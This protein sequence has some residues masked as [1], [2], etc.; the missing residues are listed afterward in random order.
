MT[1]TNKSHLKKNKN[2]K[3]LNKNCIQRQKWKNHFLA[4]AVYSVIALDSIMETPRYLILNLD[5]PGQLIHHLTSWLDSWLA[6]WPINCLV[7]WLADEFLLV[8]TAQQYCI[9]SGGPA[10]G[11]I[12]DW[13]TTWP[14][15]C[16]SDCR[17]PEKIQ[18]LIEWLID[19]DM[20]VM[21]LP[22]DWP[23]RLRY[24]ML[25]E[26]WLHLAM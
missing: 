2:K 23:A 14:T 13:V 26:E 20:E 10:G 3:T 7:N 15:E 11:Q 22:S 17:D 19:T 24:W 1:L 6:W 8:S 25:T 12:E 21:L 5:T 18:Q 9:P 16:P 4:H